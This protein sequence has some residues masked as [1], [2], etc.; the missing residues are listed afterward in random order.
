MKPRRRSD[1]TVGRGLR[2]AIEWT[3]IVLTVAVLAVAV[4]IPKVAGA[5]PYTVLTGSMRPTMPPGAMVVVRPVDQS[6]VTV[7]DVVTYLPRSGSA[8]VVTHRV[9]ATGIDATGRPVFMTKGD[10][11]DA[12]D[13][14]P[15]H[16]YQLVGKRWYTMP[17]LGYLTRLLNGTERAIATRAAVIG[18]LMYML[19]MYASAWRD[20]R[21]RSVRRP[22]VSGSRAR[23]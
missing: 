11:N 3:L 20:R 7:G 21:R 17:Y 12:V 18:L 9:V 10:A 4:V 2:Q 22:E 6:Q 14:A 13:P 5:T 1:D 19:F 15:V 23:A 8:E 16:G